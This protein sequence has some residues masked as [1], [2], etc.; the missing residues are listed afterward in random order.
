VR[1]LS[2]VPYADVMRWE[3]GGV[4]FT[5]EMG[6]RLDLSGVTWAADNGCYTSGARFDVGRWLAFLE[7]WHGHGSCLFAVLPDVPFDH[8]ATIKRSLP[9]VEAVRQ[10]GYRPALAIQNGADVAHIPWETIEAVFIAGDKS[11]KTSTAAWMICREAK[12]RRLHVHIARRNSKRAM[13]AAYDMG[14]DTI[15]GTFL[16]Y[17]PDFNW[18]RMQRWFREFCPHDKLTIWGDDPRFW[19]CRSCGCAIWKVV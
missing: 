14:A 7:S 1:Y 11:F 10:L 16:K 15:D 18:Q 9:H 12:R 19:R 3:Q 2:G 5:P 8:D 6:N 4:M 17:A 13:Q